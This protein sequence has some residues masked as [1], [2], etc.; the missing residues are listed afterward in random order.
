MESLRTVTYRLI[1]MRQN[2]S[3][4]LLLANGSGRTLPR[5]E[6]H[7]QQRLAE[8]LTAQVRKAL[9]LEA[10]CL[11]VP[12]ARTSDQNRE[13]R[14]ALMESV[15]PNDRSPGEARWMPAS[16]AS[17]SCRPEETRAI[18]DALAEL[19]S[20]TRG[21]AGCGNFSAGHRSKLHRWAYD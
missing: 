10:Y 20:Y 4:I 6:I 8:Q 5:V 12:S 1:V 17:G 7:P 16:A 3:E 11:F 15:R 2:A 14:Y 19:D 21:P 13:A 18:R 9:G